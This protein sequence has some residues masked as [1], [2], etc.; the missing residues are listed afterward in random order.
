MS[1]SLMNPQMIQFISFSS[2]STTGVVTFIF[3]MPILA[4]FAREEREDWQ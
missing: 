2:S 1:V 4:L 3:A